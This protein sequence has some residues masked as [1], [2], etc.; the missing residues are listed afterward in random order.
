[1][2]R[3]FAAALIQAGFKKGDCIATVLPNVP[4]YA[5]A[6]F[7]IWEAGLVCS[8]VNPSYTTGR[9]HVMWE[10]HAILHKLH[11]ARAGRGRLV[12]GSNYK[13]LSGSYLHAI[14]YFINILD[15]IQRQLKACN[16]KAAI[17]T[18]NFL[19]SIQACQSSG[20][21]PDLKSI[22]L[23][24]APHPGCH[25]FSEMIKVDP[26]HV[27]FPPNSQFNTQEDTSLL[28][29]SSGTTGLPKGNHMIRLQTN[30]MYQCTYIHVNLLRN[31]M[32]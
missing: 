7:G 24:G 30:T 9:W 3:S 10:I 11:I 15:E 8:P 4:E 12:C 23:L 18:P 25:T 1:M 21:C 22:I 14:K 2:S 16:A 13:F 26:R 27:E 19:A 32:F 20:E 5:S 29:F 17:T 28:P 6:M 31:I